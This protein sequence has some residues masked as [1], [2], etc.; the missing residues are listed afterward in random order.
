MRIVGTSSNVISQ[1]MFFYSNINRGRGK[2]G[3]TTF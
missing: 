1:E 2:G 3:K